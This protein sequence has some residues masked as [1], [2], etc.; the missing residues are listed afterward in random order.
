MLIP[1]NHEFRGDKSMTLSQILRD[2]RISPS[3]F[4]NFRT[5]AEQTSSESGSRDSAAEY[6]F[7][8]LTARDR[9]MTVGS[10]GRR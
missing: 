5:Q 2:A 3:L 7:D 1:G 9:D 8:R 10:I 6:M 4:W